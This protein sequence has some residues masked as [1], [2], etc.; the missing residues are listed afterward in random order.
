MLISDMPRLGLAVLA[1]AFVFAS[2]AA[3]GDELAEAGKLLRS[4][5]HQEAME[6]VNKVLAAKPKDP[7]ARFLKGLIYTEQGNTREAIEMFRKLTE[8]YPELPEPYNNLAVIYASQGQYDKA[9]AALE[10][11]IRT[12]PSYATA[13]ENLGD[14]YAKLASQ[15][16][17]KAL[18]LDSSNAGAQN[19]LA[20]VRELV[21][22]S[23]RDATPVRIAA[24]ET[25]P[26]PA[27]PAAAKA[28]AA[29]AAPAKAAPAK[30]AAQKP[31]APQA[32]ASKPAAAEQEEVVAALKAWAQAWSRKD[33]DAYLA[34]YAKDFRTPRGE[35]RGD[36]ENARRQRLQAP[37]S[38]SVTVEEPKVT[39][40][41]DARASVTFRQDYKSDFLSSRSTKTLV[42]VKSEGGRWLIQQEQVTN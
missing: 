23:A 14:V 6:R 36:W 22:N 21:G 1:A 32:S 38:I 37:K 24:A 40:R 27:K 13:Y 16:Y 20:L 3:R 4:G 25:K 41:D 2:A 39:R 33:V 5:Q 26:A 30:A 15:A 29:K 17:D 19:K 7:Q 12:H 42:M 10:K 31:A 8:D 11:S 18:K 34:F 9:R 28:A 35:A